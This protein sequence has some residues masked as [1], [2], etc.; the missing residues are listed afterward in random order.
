MF[1]GG[2]V[3]RLVK[4]ILMLCLILKNLKEFEKYKWVLNFILL[5]SCCL[6]LNYFIFYR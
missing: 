4:Y 5:L 3:F 6:I 2:F 1:V